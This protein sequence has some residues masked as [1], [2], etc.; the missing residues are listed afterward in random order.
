MVSSL[1]KYAYYGRKTVP[2]SVICTYQYGIVPIAPYNNILVRPSTV[3]I[4]LQR[5][6]SG[7]NQLLGPT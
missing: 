7:Y 6:Y 5:G 4:R 1:H 2:I 3:D